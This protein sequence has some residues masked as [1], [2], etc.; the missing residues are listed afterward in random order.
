MAV[1]SILYEQTVL[2]NVHSNVT[3]NHGVIQLNPLTAQIYGGQENG[4]ITVDTRPSPMTYAVNAKLTNVDANQLLS[5][6]SSVKD[7]LYGTLAP[8]PNVTFATP[9]SGD[10]VQTLNGTLDYEPDEWQD[11][12]ARPAERAV[13]DRQVRRRRRKGYTAISQM[14]STFNIHNGVAQTNDMKAALDVGND[15]G[16]RNHQPGQPG[17]QHARDRGAEQGLQPVGGRHGSWRLSEH[18][19]GQQ[20][21]RAGDAGDHHGNHE[22]S[23]G[24]ARRAAD[25][26]M[27]L[28]NLLPTAGGLDERRAAAN[29]LG[30]LVGGLLGGQQQ[31]A[32]RRPAQQ[33]QQANPLND[34][35]NQLLGGKKKK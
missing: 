6:I 3:L 30:G 12:E 24:R 15:D 27:K 16:H 28:N 33:N 26:Q 13:E 14:S 10:I 19:A 2:T 9:P 35:L 23:D 34:T 7:T 20:E 11:H 18:C 31:Q 8:T 22:S 5:S 17:P 1:G 25:C 21:R 29:D 32:K 4:S